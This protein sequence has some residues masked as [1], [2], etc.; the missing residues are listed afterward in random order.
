LWLWLPALA[1]CS[2]LPPRVFFLF[3]AMSEKS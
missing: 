1:C 3:S 2:E